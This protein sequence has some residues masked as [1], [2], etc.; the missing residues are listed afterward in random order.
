MKPTQLAVDQ[1]AGAG[2]IEICTLEWAHSRGLPG[3]QGLMDIAAWKGRLSVLKWLQACRNEGCTIKATTWAAQSGHL[4]VLRWLRHGLGQECTTDALEAAATAGRVRVVAWFLRNS[5][6]QQVSTTPAVVGAAS[7]GHA[8]VLK[9]LLSSSREEAEKSEWAIALASSGNHSECVELLEDAGWPAR[10]ALASAGDGSE[11]SYKGG[12]CP[13]EEPCRNEESKKEPSS[14][15]DGGNGWMAQQR[16]GRRCSRWPFFGRPNTASSALRKRRTDIVRDAEG[17]FGGHWAEWERDS[18]VIGDI[19]HDDDEEDCG[20]DECRLVA[21]LQAT[22]PL[23]VGEKPRVR[24]VWTPVSADVPEAPRLNLGV[25][26]KESQDTVISAYISGLLRGPMGPPAADGRPR[27]RVREIPTPR[28]NN[29]S[30]GLDGRQACDSGV[31]VSAIVA[32]GGSGV[33]AVCRSPGPRGDHSER[34]LRWNS[35]SSIAAA[36]A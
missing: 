24:D 4:K 18:S 7:K 1:A 17:L 29:C 6:D 32:V 13:G 9:L 30:D 5:G 28:R 34:C 27:D 31:F 11:S 10:P 19:D 20:C 36:E 25:L 15:P 23:A 21:F 16:G 3:F 12:E 35:R 22:K 14:L 26:T 8:D 2:D 33:D